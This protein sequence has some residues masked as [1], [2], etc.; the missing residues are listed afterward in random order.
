[1]RPENPRFLHEPTDYHKL[2]Q[3]RFV[4]I[5]AI[6]HKLLIHVHI[7]A[8]YALSLDFTGA[9]VSWLKMYPWYPSSDLADFWFCG[10]D[11]RLFRYP[12]GRLYPSLS[13][14]SVWLYHCSSYRFQSSRFRYSWYLL[15]H[16]SSYRL[17]HCSSYPSWYH[18][19]S[20]RWR[21]SGWCRCR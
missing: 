14:L 2:C 18:Y 6:M 9:G 10:W 15:Y 20:Y 19:S 13:P 11:Y 1:M 16:C 17:Y 3:Y 8:I 5:S 21:D 4:T 7:S 12:C